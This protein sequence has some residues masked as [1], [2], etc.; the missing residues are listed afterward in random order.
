[1]RCDDHGVPNKYLVKDFVVTLKDINEAPTAIKLSNMKIKENSG[2]GTLVGTVSVTDPDKGQTHTCSIVAG[3]TST[4]EFRGYNLVVK[5]AII[6]YE[7]DDEYEITIQCIDN[8]SPPLSFED[9]LDIDVINVLEAP[10]DIVWAT[11]SCG[12]LPENSDAGFNIGE[13]SVLDQD[14]NQNPQCKLLDDA[15]K[16]FDVQSQ[17]TLIITAGSA[18]SALDYETMANH[19]LYL[20]VRCTDTS[21][22]YLDKKMC[23]NVTDANEPATNISLTANLVRENEYDALIGQ[24]I[25][26]G[27]PDVGQ[28]HNCTILADTPGV[29]GH[30]A[31][32]DAI[33]VF[34]VEYDASTDTNYL[35]TISSVDFEA[36]DPAVF[37]VDIRCFD[38]P[39][40]GEDPIPIEAYD[41]KVWMVDVNE[42]PETPCPQDGSTWTVREGASNGTKVTDSLDSWDP[43]NEIASEDAKNLTKGQDAPTKQHL[44]YK[45]VN[46]D[47]V[48][49]VYNEQLQR[50][51]KFGVRTNR[52][53][54]H[55]SII[56]YLS[57]STSILRRPSRTAS[58]STSWTTAL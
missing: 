38:I 33:N 48:P 46:G 53:A 56:L 43:D 58:V 16:I 52:T 24:L 42:M 44:T 32:F 30:D 49:F 12:V 3:N 55:R 9:T 25:V 37:D 50:I 4:F 26:T 8:G 40:D 28:G 20:T 1:M 13:L 15:G 10:T 18:A 11:G 27:D 35:K 5:S 6:D 39:T 17:N 41:F 21:G 29:N 22:Q 36:L 51:E 7:T 54:V 14:D 45:L 23:V 31:K 2:V 34:Y 57:F 19:M 47:R